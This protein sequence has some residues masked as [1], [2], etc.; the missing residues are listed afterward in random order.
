MTQS[1]PLNSRPFAFDTEFDGSGD[2]VR[3]STFRPAKRAYMP[4]EVE[5]LVA[6]AR[7]EAREAA[8][9]E[10]ASIEAMALSTIGQCLSAAMPALNQV[11]QTHREQSA[12]LALAAARVIAAASLE[13]LPTGP[14]QSALETLGQEIDASPR[15][16]VRSAGLDEAVQKKIQALAVDAGFSGMV[17]FR[18]DP[19]LPLAAFQLE[20]ADGRADFDPAAAAE[21]IG[22][23]LTSALASEA[24]H[25]ESLNAGS[26]H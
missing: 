8:L 25:A 11:A 21:R 26:N 19:S 10:S 9:A 5:A 7:L 24:G 23:V 15:L 6:Q 3:A 13:H 1:A 17:A 4:T 22:A 12:D 2:V 20:W 16:V 14:L 18:D